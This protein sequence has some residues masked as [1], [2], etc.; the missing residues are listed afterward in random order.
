MVGRPLGADCLVS[1][2]AVRNS[3]R[4]CSRAVKITLARHTFC[5]CRVDGYV[6]KVPGSVL[7]VRRTP[8][9]RVR[10]AIRLQ[11]RRSRYAVPGLQRTSPGRATANAGGLQVNVATAIGPFKT[12]G[13]GT[14]LIS[15]AAQ[16]SRQ[17]NT[18][19]TTAFALAK[20]CC[21][22]CFLE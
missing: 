5:F 12:I 8:R 14:S 3:F 20:L 13:L 15:L 2:V 9:S 4:N 17:T 11:M 10:R 7:G 21:F 1:V 22:V 18:R 6:R 19:A 16:T